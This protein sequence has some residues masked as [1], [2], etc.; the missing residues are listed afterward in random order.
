MKKNNLKEVSVNISA[1]EYAKKKGLFTDKDTVNIVGK[2]QKPTMGSVTEDDAVIEPQDQATIKYLSNVRDP[3]TTEVSKPFTIADKNY[4]LIRGIDA[5]KKVVNAVMCIDDNMIHTYEDFERD[6][7]LPMKERLEMESMGEPRLQGASIQTTP[8]I[9]EVKKEKETYRGSRHFFINKATN[10]VRSFSS[11]KEM[12]ECGK[13]EEEEYMGLSE[14]KKFKNEELFGSRKKINELGNEPLGAAAQPADASAQ[15]GNTQ[16]NGLE[17]DLTGKAKLLIQKMDEINVIKKGMDSVKN[18]GTDK[19]KAI[20][21]ISFAERIG[22]PKNKVSFIVNNIKDISKN[23]NT[24][25]IG[26]SKV[27]T[28]NQLTESLNTN[29]VIK[30]I[31]VKDIK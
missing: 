2:E 23:V 8:D 12:L 31:K 24:Q 28:K 9:Q 25:P 1:D 27:I 19:A 26:E 11:I 30:T 29:K 13:S 14:F 10:E 17:G 7:A 22:V 5:S 18:E 4:Q 6:I 3:E 15:G 20:V 16:Y 21:L